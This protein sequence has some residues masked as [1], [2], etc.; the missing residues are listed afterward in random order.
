MKQILRSC[1]KTLDSYFGITAKGSTFKKEIMGGLITFISMAYILIVN[2]FMLSGI[3][4]GL[5]EIEGI[6]LM[7]FDAVFMA[8]AISAAATTL[9]MGIFAK[10]PL[11]LAPG[12]GLNAFF[13]YNVAYFGMGLG[14]EKALAVVLM[15]GVLF[16]VISLTGIRKKALNAI[17][18]SIK[19]AIAAGIG[20]FIAFIGF[21]NAGIVVSN[22]ATIVSIGDLTDPGVIIA[23]AG[24]LLMT[25]LFFLK[26][27]G[28]MFISMVAVLLIGLI[29]SVTGVKTNDPHALP[30]WSSLS[31]GWGGN[32]AALGTTIGKSVVNIIPAISSV[33]GW[34][35]ILVFLFIDFFD[36]A[37]TLVAAGNAA[38][39]INKDGEIDG[40]EKAL[41]VDAI[42]TIGGAVLGTSSVTAFV[43]SNTG[44]TQ[45]AR[46]GFASVITGLLFFL[47]IFISP[48]FSLFTGTITTLALVGVGMLMISELEEIDWKDYVI[49]FT[50][51]IVIIGMLITFAIHWG[52]VFGFIFYTIS[53]LASKRHKEV[54][55]PMYGLAI[56]SVL[57]VVIEIFLTLSK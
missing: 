49:T 25:V 7:S 26:I 24:I 33:S 14:W 57:F 2:P 29:L 56:F 20:F 38:G 9:L 8:T 1:T 47:S 43:E 55:L 41:L 52:I 37:G 50:T 28:Y 23:F 15:S 45:G 3:E 27:K 30:N 22:E 53:M 4:G 31:S 48:I 51:F 34:I 40:S 11:A 42:G 44:I 35:A 5:T 21:K 13:T 36:T 54:S 39:L 16:L 17:P 46:T 19:A 32:W 10:L 12:M 18:K 6:K